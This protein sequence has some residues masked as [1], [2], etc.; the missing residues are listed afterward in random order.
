MLSNG[1]PVEMPWLGKV[2]AVLEGYLGGQA[3]GGAIA[4]LL[5][6]IA[7]PSGKLAETFPNKLV[8]NPSYLNFPGD[9]ETV[10]YREGI[11]VG[12]R[13]YDTKDV[14]IR[15]K[16]N[17][18]IIG[19]SIATRAAIDGGLHSEIAFSLSDSYIQRL[20]DLSSI[21]DIDNLQMEAI[22][23]FTNK[24]SEVKEEQYTKTIT[25][26]KNFIYSNRY[27]KITHEDVANIVQLSH[28]YLSVLF[29]R[30]V[31]ISVSDYIQKIKIEEAKNLIVHT[32]TPLS[33]IS[34]LLHFTDQ[35]YFTKVFK[36]F[37]G[38]TPKQYKE[39]H[40]LI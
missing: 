13:H 32:N 24:V 16:K 30:E 18:G 36:K 26:C 33:E 29:K 7:N 20:E 3:L 27:E 28:S 14:E 37:E 11:F 40:H 17:L 15:S 35:S 39:R 8:H 25:S 2:K 10:E 31:G 34:S 4:D 6:G 19:I 22:F 38:I 5:F 21:Q 1:A 12:Y 23:T 9:G